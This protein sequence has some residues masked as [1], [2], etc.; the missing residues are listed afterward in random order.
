M[1]NNKKEYEQSILITLHNIYYT[2]IYIGKI[3]LIKPYF[4]LKMGIKKLYIL[5]RSLDIQVLGLDLDYFGD[6][7]SYLHNDD[8]NISREQQHLVQKN[9]RYF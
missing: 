4:Q 1:K 8:L 5:T 6:Y 7:Q 3:R 9:H 2:H